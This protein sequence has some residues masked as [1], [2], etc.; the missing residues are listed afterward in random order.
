[1]E[2]EPVLSYTVMYCTVII[3][4]LVLGIGTGTGTEGRTFLRVSVG[5]M[6]VV[7]Y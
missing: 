4:V 1:M 5:V 7:S 2:G 3:A 6:V